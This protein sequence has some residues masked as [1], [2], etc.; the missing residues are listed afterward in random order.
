MKYARPWRRKISIRNRKN[1]A[2]APAATPLPMRLSF[3]CTSALASSISSWTSSEAL[4]EMSP[5]MSPRRF[6]AVSGGFRPSSLIVLPCPLQELRQEEA[7]GER[8]ADEDLGTLLEGVVVH[9]LVRRDR[10]LRSLGGGLGRRRLGLGLPLGGRGRL[11]LLLRRHRDG[12]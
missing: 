6:S 9:G 3:C 8:R 11:R 10:A 7:A 4:S 12:G 1:P 2:T 5:T